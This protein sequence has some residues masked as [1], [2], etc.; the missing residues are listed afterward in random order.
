[1]IV[2]LKLEC[3]FSIHTQLEIVCLSLAN[4]FR[5]HLR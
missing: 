3:N 2:I 5:G 4:I 1:M